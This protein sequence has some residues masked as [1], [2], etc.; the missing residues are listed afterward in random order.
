MTLRNK[1]KLSEIFHAKGFS[2]LPNFRRLI[3]KHEK[4]IKK[5][6]LLLFSLL[7]INIG[8]TQT[9]YF[10]EVK[11]LTDVTFPE[12]CLEVV[13][14]TS[15]DRTGWNV[16]IYNGSGFLIQSADLGIIAPT[17][18]KADLDIVIIDV[19]MAVPD[20]GMVIEDNGGAIVQFLSY[21]AGTITAQDGPA[22]TL[23]SEY[24]G[25]QTVAGLSLQLAGT[26][27]NYTDFI[28]LPPG[29]SGMGWI[30][31]AVSCGFENDLQ[32]LIS[33]IIVLPVELLYFN[34]DLTGE[35]VM[36]KWATSSEYNS[37]HYILQRSVNGSQFEEIQRIKAA[38]FS[39]E[40]ISYSFL[41]RYPPKGSLYYQLTE[42]DLDGSMIKSEI[43][44]VK[45]MDDENKTLIFPNPVQKNVS[46]ILPYSFEF[47]TI[48]VFDLITGR[49]LIQQQVDFPDN[50]ITLNTNSLGQGQFL[51]RLRST[52]YVYEQRIVKINKYE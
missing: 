50:R 35:N 39:N 24:I 21:G 12:Q 34:A 6:L 43:V 33:P 9:T 30:E 15:Q 5:L 13:S 31:D 25:A 11:Y 1:K 22:A 49:V 40:L 38:G 45:N 44:A 4:M 52:N 20:G 47:V 27:T 46:I 41:D 17:S 8:F 7:T 42:I 14:P 37:S 2:Y 10:N 3:K 51:I 18:T 26:G 19:V 28:T 29:G 48:E 32:T 16:H 23:T 36:T